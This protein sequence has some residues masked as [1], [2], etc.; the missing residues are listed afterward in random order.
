MTPAQVLTVDGVRLS[1]LLD[2]RYGDGQIYLTHA[3][4]KP[5]LR[6]AIRLLGLVSD[7]GYVTRYGKQWWAQHMYH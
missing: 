1:R 3:D 7:E 6:A 4:E 5:I 2:H